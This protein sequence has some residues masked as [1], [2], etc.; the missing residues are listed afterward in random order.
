MI[1]ALA[2]LM[3]VPPLFDYFNNTV[4]REKPFTPDEKAKRLHASLFVADLHSDSL[5]WN[6]DLLVEN[7]RGHVDLPRLV[8]GNVALQ[9]FTVV[10]KTPKSMNYESNSGDTDNITTLAIMQ[11]WPRATYKSLLQRALYQ[12]NKLRD[13]ADRSKGAL[14]IITTGKDLDR[15]LDKRNDTPHA[16]A[17]V[18]GIEGLHC[19]EGKLENIDRLYDAG[20][21]M[22]GITHFFDNELGGSAHGVQKGGLTPFGREC[23]KKMEEKHILID[24]AHASPAVIDDVLAMATR[25]VVMSHGGVKGTCDKTRNLSDDH[26]KRIAA[27]G[28]VVGIGYWEEAV[29]GTDVKAIVRAIRYAVSIAGV[30]HVALGSDFDGV[31]SAPFD[32]SGLA[33]ITEE[34]LNEGFQ[35]IDI[36]KIMGG[37]TLRLFRES[38]P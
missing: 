38:L 1:A 35:E 28:G 14:T 16:V 20:F 24:L 5:L 30:D 19:A 31:I 33:E 22:M 29:C 10:T 36:A 4:K 18:L 17:A 11:R 3:F 7:S 8:R 12:A 32:T 34:L 13:M 37:N 25:P 6:R 9:A 21:R 2:S 15:F 23:V 26:V 27:T